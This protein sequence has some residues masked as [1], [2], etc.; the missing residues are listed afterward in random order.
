M[1]L[2]I[3]RMNSISIDADDSSLSWS[4]AVDVHYGVCMSSE[5]S[6]SKI[7]WA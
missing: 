2:D 3:E 4:V 6:R 7:M 5:I 1:C